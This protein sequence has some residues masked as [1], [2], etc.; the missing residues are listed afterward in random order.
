VVPSEVPGASLA[1]TTYE[2]GRGKALPDGL[3][4]LILRPLTGRTHQLRAQSSARGMPI[5]GDATYG[6]SRPFPVG[7]A[8]HARALTVEHPVR[9]RPMT[10]EAPTPDSWAG[11]LST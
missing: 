9:R 5:A 2:V 7:I 3:A 6:A 8:L 1:S 10:V 4:W 11:W